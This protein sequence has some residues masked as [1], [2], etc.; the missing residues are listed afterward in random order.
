M[1]LDSDY[2]RSLGFK[3]SPETVEK[4]KAA[5]EQAKKVIHDFDGIQQLPTAIREAN[6]VRRA[7]TLRLAKKKKK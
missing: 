5:A 4:W 2:L 1:K 7:H 6:E 3:V